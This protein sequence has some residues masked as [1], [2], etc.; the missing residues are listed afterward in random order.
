MIMEGWHTH[1]ERLAKDAAAQA[2]AE[3]E[4]AR[5]EQAD[6]VRSMLM[7]GF[8]GKKT[9]P[10]VPPPGFVPDDA[11]RQELDGQ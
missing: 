7:Q 6:R 5:R 9:K 2:R 10:G 11:Q 4:K 1:K 8:Q 3:Q